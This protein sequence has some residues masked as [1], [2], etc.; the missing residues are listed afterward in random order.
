MADPPEVGSVWSF[1]TRPCTV[2]SPPDTG[3]Y[4]VLKVIEATPRL[5]AVVLIDGVWNAADAEAG[6]VIETEEREDIRRVLEER[7]HVARQKALVEEIDAW[8]AW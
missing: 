1:R 3:R 4:A 7:A 6:E 5:I 2:F 8:R